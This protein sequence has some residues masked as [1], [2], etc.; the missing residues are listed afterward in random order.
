M[1]KYFTY[2]EVY[3][4]VRKLCS[5][6][7]KMGVKTGSNVGMLCYNCHTFLEAYF[8]TALLGAILVPINYR[9]S[10]KEIGFI[11]DDAELSLLI[12]HF[13]FEPLVKGSLSYAGRD[14]PVIWI[15]PD[16]QKGLLSYEELLEEAEE[17]SEDAWGPG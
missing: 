2:G 17:Y 13:D 12:S 15:E 10:E 9:L 7:E 4:R 6:L 16:S 11:V 3:R 1:G 14:V 8:A 5:V